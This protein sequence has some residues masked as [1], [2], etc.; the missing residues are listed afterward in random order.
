MPI[1]ETMTA[2][3]FAECRVDLPDGGRW[4]ELIEGELV[5]FDPPSAKHGST[6]MNLTK[7]LGQYLQDN[8]DALQGRMG[9]EQG[10]LVSRD[11]DTLCFPDICYCIGGP[12]FFDPME[13]YSEAPAQLVIEVI[14]SQR[15]FKD[16]LERAELYHQGGV[17]QLWMLDTQE[18]EVAIYAEGELVQVLNQRDVLTGGEVFSEF[19]ISVEHLFTEPDW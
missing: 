2:E 5:T 16:R 19:R 14:S 12:R 17:E 7:M 1:P 6:V 15:R 13:V 8:C 11:P 9:F 18:S 3:Q 10:L 4:T